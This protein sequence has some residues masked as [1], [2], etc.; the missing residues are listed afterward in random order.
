MSLY[1]LFT[2][3][4]PDDGAEH[5]D[6]LHS[7]P[8][9]KIE[10]IVSRGQSTP[11]GEWY[12]QPHDEWVVLLTGEAG[13]L[14]EGHDTITMRQGDYVFLPAHCRHRVEWTAPQCE[15]IWLAVQITPPDGAT[16][17]VSSVNDR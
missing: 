9:V 14:I 13:L 3:L 2:H 12:D 7:T 4:P 1:N 11:P 15:S 17:E 10:R 16:S 5:F 8:G 6:I